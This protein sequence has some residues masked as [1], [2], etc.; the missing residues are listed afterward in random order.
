MIT[1]AKKIPADPVKIQDNTFRGDHQSIYAPRITD[2]M[3]AA[4]ARCVEEKVSREDFEQGRIFQSL[5]RIREVS[6]HIAISV[7]KAAFTRK[8]TAM[9]EPADLP[10]F[11]KSRMYDP[12]YPPYPLIK[13]VAKRNK[14]MYKKTG[15]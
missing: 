3:F 1:A 12:V 15:I 5:S 2:E 11:I 8:L 10:G 6:L 7:A 13:K 4:A 9:K 14:E